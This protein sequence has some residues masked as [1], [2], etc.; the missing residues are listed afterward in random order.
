MFIGTIG[1]VA[2][3]SGFPAYGTFLS[4]YCAATSGLDASGTMRYGSW[5]SHSLYADGIGGSYD[6]FNGDNTG[7][8]YYPA[9]YYTYY[10]VDYPGEFYWENV[11]GSNQSGIYQWFIRWN[12]IYADGNGGSITFSS[13]SSFHF[14]GDIISQWQDPSTLNTWTVIFDG[15]SGYYITSSP[16]V[17]G[18]FLYSVCA[19]AHL[20]DAVGTGW[21]TYADY[22]YV[23]TD[24]YGGT[25]YTL[26][27][28]N[29]NGCWLP[30]GFA[31]SKPY[32]YGTL[33]YQDQYFQQQSW[34]YST[35]WTLWT[36]LGDGTQINTIGEDRAD[37]GYVFY[38]WSYPYNEGTVW[39][40]NYYYDGGAGYY[41]S[42]GEQPV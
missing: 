22:S 18:I 40:T 13:G 8:C 10:L 1:I 6:V 16:P 41:I 28:R 27:G 36:E 14:A 26:I 12:Y 2:G 21:D 37:A 9:G 25:Y 42:S 5:A 20:T 7:G 29:T 4:T 33:T 3:K 31:A 30:A 23:Y 35:A 34:T 32:T 38:S 19:Y 24:G 39:M 11:M 15:Y 17:A